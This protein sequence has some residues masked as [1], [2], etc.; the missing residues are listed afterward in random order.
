[1]N[2]EANVFSDQAKI[3]Y[4]C[5]VSPFA[6]TFKPLHLVDM[7]QVQ[8]FMTTWYQDHRKV[9]TGKPYLPQIYLLL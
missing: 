2:Y 3:P 5:H 7:S 8:Q 9:K 1:M 6:I 4:R